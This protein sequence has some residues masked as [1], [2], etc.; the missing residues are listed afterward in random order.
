MDA[1]LTKGDLMYYVITTPD[2]VPMRLPDGTAY[3]EALS[4]LEAHSSTGT[5]TF[6]LWRHNPALEGGPIVS[7]SQIARAAAGKPTTE[8]YP[9][10]G[11]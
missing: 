9:G 10:E 2:D 1:N 4:V 5:G 6:T 7:R 3:Q 11:R 8:R